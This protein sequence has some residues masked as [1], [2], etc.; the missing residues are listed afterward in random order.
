MAEEALRKLEEQ[1]RC[2]ICLHTYTDPKQLQCHH[3]FC[4]QCLVPLVV[5]DGW[6][7]NSLTCPNCRQVTPIPKIGLQSAFHIT[8]LLEIQE[9]FKK[10]KNSADTLE[11]AAGGA[12][13]G[14][15]SKTEL[16]YCL[17]H[18]RRVLDLYCETCEELVCVQCIMKGGKHRDHDHAVI[19]DAY[20]KHKR[21]IQSAIKPLEEQVADIQR[22]LAQLGRGSDEICDQRTRTED[23][24]HA[25][26][27]QLQ[28]ILNVR[29]TELVAKLNKITEGKMKYLAAQRDQIETILAQRN[30]CLYFLRENLMTDDKSCLLKAKATVK[31]IRA[32]LTPFQLL[33]WKPSVQAD[34]HVMFTPVPADTPLKTACQSHGEIVTAI[35]P[36]PSR[37]HAS[38]DGLKVAVVGEKCTVHLTTSR[39]TPKP[40]ISLECSLISE[41][42]GN[43]SVTVEKRGV[44]SY[45]ISYLPTVKG[46]HQL[47]INADGGH[48]PGSP[49]SVVVTSSIEKL[50]TL[51]HT[52]PGLMGPRGIA[53]NRSGEVVVT[54]GRARRVSVFTPGGVKLRSFG[55][56]Q[57]MDPGGVTV[58]GEGNIV[59]VD[60][61]RHCVLKFN[62]EGQFIKSFSS[63]ESGSLQ[64]SLPTDIAFNSKKNCFYVLDMGSRRIHLLMSNLTDCKTSSPF[65]QFSDRVWGI[66]CDEDGD[67][68]IADTNKHRVHVFSTKGRVFQ[69]GSRGQGLSLPTGVCID[70]DRRV[71]VSE[72]CRGNSRVSVFSRQGNFL[73]SFQWTSKNQD[74]STPSG[75]AVDGNGVLYVC[76]QAE[77]CVRIY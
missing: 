14:M 52:I 23:K 67:G 76:D 27:R 72:Y 37:F 22:S 75:L 38:G 69:F 40:L 36:D 42:R 1:L 7:R 66:A 51:M 16:H 5:R 62:K 39:F 73:K 56:G 30:S 44:E 34:T 8:P 18:S 33:S 41:L 59:V 17:V 49:F 25:T 55:E 10:L 68:Y 70:S 4:Q 35:L 31:K 28:E 58:D 21:E 24:I 77:S 54:E 9:S 46:R 32:L 43:C 60:M 57:L 12:A 63:L 19:E 50:G 29:E 26:F 6:G 13:T 65:E 64:L 45:D 48:I 47:L 3:V 11:G 74:Y 15:S 71:Y 20:E 53:I 61:G 2:S